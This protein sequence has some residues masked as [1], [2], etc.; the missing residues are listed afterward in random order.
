MTPAGPPI[1]PEAIAIGTGFGGVFGKVQ[2]ATDSPA[3]I[4]IGGGNLLAHAARNAYDSLDFDDLDDVD[5][6]EK[7]HIIQANG[8][9]YER[10]SQERTSEALA[11]TNELHAGAM[12]GAMKSSMP[13]NRCCVMASSRT[14]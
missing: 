11:R 14:P 13:S 12:A 1:D 7:P 3:D 9:R 2:R 8:P 4:P 6:S 10:E 5:P